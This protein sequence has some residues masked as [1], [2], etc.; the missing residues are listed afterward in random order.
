MD[1]KQSQEVI[2]ST[3]KKKK[4]RSRSRSPIKSANDSSQSK[5]SDRS[6]SPKKDLDST[7]RRFGKVSKQLCQLQT[8]QA[9]L[10]STVVKTFQ[11][12][13]SPIVDWLDT[14]TDL[15]SDH[16]EYKRMTSTEMKCILGQQIHCSHCGSEGSGGILS[17]WV[18]ES[19]F[20]GLYYTQSQRDVL[21]WI[22]DFL[23]IRHPKKTSHGWHLS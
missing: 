1:S 2:P 20:M 13:F 12:E 15:L 21:F 22:I 18:L 16:K 14:Q 8:K 4:T 7:L 11:K 5:R 17:Q 9:D 3:E 19:G 10:L 6:R 23:N